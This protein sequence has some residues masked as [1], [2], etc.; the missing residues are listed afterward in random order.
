VLPVLV[1]LLGEAGVTEDVP[2]A[3]CQLVEP[4]T[5]L[6]Q[7]AADADAI[8]KLAALLRCAAVYLCRSSGSG[9]C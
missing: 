3:L 7:A 5:E 6:Q 9:T 4:S 1:R 2:G 8:V